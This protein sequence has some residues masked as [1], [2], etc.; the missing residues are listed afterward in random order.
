MKPL[1]LLSFV[2][3]I[4]M[5]FYA[6]PMSA[7]AL[8]IPSD[9]EVAEKDDFE[10]SETASA[11]DNSEWLGEMIS[12]RTE[13]AKVYRM[14]DGSYRYLEYGTKI[15]YYNKNGV[16]TDYDNTLQSVEGRDGAVYYAPVSSNIDVRFAETLE[17]DA[18]FSVGEGNVGLAVIPLDNNP[19]EA[20]V[21]QKAKISDEKDSTIL[22]KHTSGLQYDGIW[23]NTAVQYVICGDT[24]KESIIVGRQSDRY[25]YRF[26]LRTEGL[27]AELEE[28]AVLLSDQQGEVRFSIPAGYMVDERGAYSDAVTYELEE[29]EEGYILTVTADETWINDENRAFPVKIDPTVQRGVF[30]PTSI[31]DASAYEGQ[32]S[33]RTTSSEYMLSGYSPDTNL[34]HTRAYIRLNA[35]PEFPEA[36]IITQ[37]VLTLQQTSSANGWKSYGGTA[38]SLTFGAYRVTSS[39]S[40]S[41]LTWNNRPSTDSIVLDYDTVTANGQKYCYFDITEVV[42]KWYEGTANNYGIAIVPL[43]EYVTGDSYAHAGFYSSENT[44]HAYEAKPMFSITFRDA[45]G[46]DSRWNYNVHSADGAGNGY[47][48]LFNGNL[49]LSATDISTAGSVLP[50]TVSHVYNGFQKK[51]QFTAP[52]SNASITNFENMKMG[53]GFKLNVCE[54]IASVSIGGYPSGY[55]MVYNDADGTELY[56]FRNGTT[57]TPTYISEDGYALKIMNFGAGYIMSD[58]YGN[59]KYFDAEGRLCAVTDNFGNRKNFVYENGKLVRITR[60]LGEETETLLVFQYNTAN[61]LSRIYNAKDDTQSVYF[62]YSDLPQSTMINSEVGYLRQI[63]CTWNGDSFEYTYYESGELKSALNMRSG[64]GVQYQYNRAGKVI[65]VSE[66]YEETKIGNTVSFAYKNKTT[67]VRLGSANDLV[68]VYT[69]DNAGRTICAYTKNE[70]DGT[71]YGAANA[72]YNENQSNEDLRKKNTVSSESQ[73]GGY[74]NNLLTNGDME[75][76]TGWLGETAKTSGIAMSRSADVLYNGLRSMKIA[77]TASQGYKK[78]SVAVDIPAAGTYTFSAMIKADPITMVGSGDNR[79]IL[80]ALGDQTVYCE[81]LPNANV[82]DGWQRYSVTASFDVP[83][84]TTVSIGLADALRLEGYNAARA[85]KYPL[86]AQFG[87]QQRVRFRFCVDT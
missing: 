12:K 30:S 38:E 73:T 41:T 40:E 45:K 15:H 59:Q 28:N 79:G 23:D 77:A 8:L 5:V 68:T 84:T 55:W 24:V 17:K 10:K 53:Y 78:Y 35:L 3:S 87:D 85:R 1:R 27:R 46:L 7:F 42:R 50:I 69:F 13:T 49:V 74:V 76:T 71:V 66:L 86:A 21:L 57:G 43:E 52:S 22:T 82:Q 37:A 72:T 54:S 62:Y 47:V 18:L 70:S 26:L 31:D 67:E 11:S 80:M 33:T 83:T 48:N 2:L 65:G 56:F 14:A 9:L 20:T 4:L 19:A 34:L 36:S 58:D 63:Y 51:K 61:S 32:P 44:N 81:A 6:I 75:T 39:W 16:L 60:N 64:L 25:M 29:C